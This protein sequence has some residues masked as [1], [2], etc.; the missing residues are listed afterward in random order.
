[1]LVGASCYASCLRD[2]GCSAHPVFPAPSLPKRANEME[3]SGRIA[4][5]E[6]EVVFSVVARMSVATSGT[7]LTLPRMSLRSSG[8]RVPSAMAMTALN[9]SNRLPR[10][11]HRRCKPAID[12]DRLAVDVGG[13][14]ARQEQAHRRE[15]MRL[16][17]ALQRIELAD[18]VLRAAFLGA[19]EHWLGHAGLDQ[20]GADRVDAHAGA[21]Q[22]IGGGLNETDDA[23]LA[24][25]VGMSAGA[26]L[27]ARDRRGAD[28]R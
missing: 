3:N 9:Q 12:R 20:A 2:R 18:L 8:L 21:G 11:R 27:E 13:V 5:R 28:D 4:P 1:M 17:G 16:A 24:G 26:G 19:V 15:F 10:I 22:R 23:G 7:T 25:A 14:V 6:R